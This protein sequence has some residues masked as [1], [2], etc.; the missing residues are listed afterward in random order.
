MSTSKSQNCPMGQKRTLG[1]V[2]AK[3]PFG[4]LIL[5]KEETH[6][7]KVNEK[8]HKVK[9]KFIMFLIFLIFFRFLFF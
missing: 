4:R 8:G 1:L 5:K 9:M 2:S 6:S 7:L 3:V